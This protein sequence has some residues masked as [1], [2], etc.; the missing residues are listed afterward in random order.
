MHLSLGNLSD[1][2]LIEPPV[3]CSVWHKLK[4]SLILS[5]RNLTISHDGILSLYPL[6]LFNLSSV[7]VYYRQ[8][9]YPFNC[10]FIYFLPYI[11]IHLGNIGVS[12]NIIL[13]FNHS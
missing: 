4:T 11:S 12:H 9:I 3:Y 6:F 2:E 10:I 7:Y 13:S 5:L 1:I 8:Y